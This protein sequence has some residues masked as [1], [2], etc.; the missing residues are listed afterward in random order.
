[1]RKYRNENNQRIAAH[2]TRIFGALSILKRAY[3]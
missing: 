2:A 3:A 1:M